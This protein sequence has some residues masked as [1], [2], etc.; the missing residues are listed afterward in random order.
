VI[1]W[2]GQQAWPA[3]AGRDGLGAGSAR[4]LFRSR[5]GRRVRAHRDHPGQC[6]SPF[7]ARTS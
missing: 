4:G 2:S 3:P 5:Q 1:P 6:V 7:T